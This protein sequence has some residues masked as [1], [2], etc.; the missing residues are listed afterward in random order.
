MKV[1]N[2]CFAEI[3]NIYF[4]DDNTLII[5]CSRCGKRD[6]IKLA[7]TTDGR[8]ITKSQRY[9]VLK[10]QKWNCNN[11]GAK[12]KYG[13]ENSWEGEVAHIDHI[14]PYTKRETYSNGK[15]NINELSN[16]QGLCPDCNLKKGKKEVN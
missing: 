2:D 13:K 11:C 4:D 3:F 7:N 15:E 1:C 6:S 10:R 12:L 9:E 5:K 8:Y 14:H 16:L